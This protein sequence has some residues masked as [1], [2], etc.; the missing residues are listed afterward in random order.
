MSIGAGMQLFSLDANINAN[1]EVLLQI[2]GLV[3]GLCAGWLVGADV[4]CCQCCQHLG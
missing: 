3:T 2:V 1:A 4:V